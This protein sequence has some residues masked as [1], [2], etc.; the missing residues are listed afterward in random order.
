MASERLADE[1]RRR[2]VAEDESRSLLTELRALREKLLTERA[3]SG[4]RA[5]EYEAE[6]SRVKTQ[7]WHKDSELE[8]RL[9]ALTNTLMQKHVALETATTERNALRL[10][11]VLNT[12]FSIF[13]RSSSYLCL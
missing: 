5:Q 11:Q 9:D 4:V 1:I 7:R 8:A 2:N 13:I 12:Y 10:A 6:I 3:D